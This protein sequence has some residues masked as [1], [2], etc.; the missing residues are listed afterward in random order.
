[1]ERKDGVIA[2]HAEG[3]ADRQT[4][5][6]QSARRTRYVVEI[7][8]RIAA[9]KEQGRRDDTALYRQRCDGGFDGAGR[10][11]CMPDCALDAA[12]GQMASMFAEYLFDGGGFDTVAHQRAGGM[13]VDITDVA[14]GQAAVGKTAQHR[15]R[16][17]AGV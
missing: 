12:D 16:L 7:A 15:Q 11:D 5:V 2:A 14:C 9:F 1:P 3:V 6:K 17:T 4:Q 10:T 13:G 8:L